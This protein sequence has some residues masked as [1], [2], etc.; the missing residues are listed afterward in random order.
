MS[1][2]DCLREAE[3]AEA[4]ACGQWPQACPADLR[5]H[6]AVCPVCAEV[7]AVMEPLL[8]EKARAWQEAS[9]PAAHVVWW[10]AQIRARAEAQR[11]VAQPMSFAQAAAA[12]SV[13]ALMLAMMPD[14]VEWFRRR[15]LEAGVF[16]DL[17]ARLATVADAAGSAGAGTFTASVV[18]AG[19]AACAVLASVALYFVLVD[20]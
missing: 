3:V 17:A 16:Q 18:A 4:V 8:Y 15:V 5:D 14:F 12:V 19:L 10:R 7:V 2:T 1:A 9:V 20:E 6:V 11:T 13:V